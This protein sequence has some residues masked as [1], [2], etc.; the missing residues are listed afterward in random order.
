LFAAKYESVLGQRVQSLLDM[1]EETKDYETF[2]KRLRE[3]MAEG[4][5]AQ[6]QQA[7]ERASI[8]ARLMGAFRQQR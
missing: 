7:I 2:S 6:S 1:A 3:M 5:P 8:F 4:A